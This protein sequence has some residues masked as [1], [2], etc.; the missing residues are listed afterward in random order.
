MSKK[1]EM[2]SRDPVTKKAA[3]DAHAASVYDESP[4]N[5]RGPKA[6]AKRPAKSIATR[7]PTPIPSNMVRKGGA[8]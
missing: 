4:A 5:M 8:K 3:T 6:P 1:T 7:G 2:L